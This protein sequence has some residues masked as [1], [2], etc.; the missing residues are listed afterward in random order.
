MTD[1]SETLHPLWEEAFARIREF[2][3]GETA[4]DAP[5]PGHQDDLPPALKHLVKVFGLSPFE[6]DIVTLCL[7]M[8]LDVGMTRACAKGHGGQPTGPTAGLVLSRIPGA[9]WSAFSPDGSLRQWRLV[10]L[11]DNLSLTSA[12]LRLDERIVHH[13]L[14]L[15][16]MDARLTTYLGR[17]AGPAWLPG[18]LRRRAHQLAEHLREPLPPVIQLVAAD[19]RDAMLLAAAACGSL[20]LP[21]WRLAADNLPATPAERDTFRLLWQRE[22]RLSPKGLL[23]R[24]GRRPAS[25]AAAAELA[26]ASPWVFVVGGGRLPTLQRPLLR[27]PVAKPPAMEQTEAWK[28]LLGVEVHRVN[29][30][31]T[32]VTSQFSLGLASLIHAAGRA[33]RRLRNGR[34]PGRVLWEVCREAARPR[35]SALAQEIRPMAC[36]DDLVLPDREQLVLRTI[37]A[38]VRHQHRVYEDGGFAEKSRR[39]LG[40]SALF[41]GDSGTGKTMAAEVL[42]GE[43]DLGLFRIDL[44]AVVDKYIGET[45]KNLRAVFNAAE[46]G[47]AILLFDEADALFGKRSDVRDSHDRYANIEVSYLLQRMEN[48]RGLAILTTNMKS[49]LDRAFIRRIRFMVEFPFPNQQL[50]TRIWRKVFPPNTGTGTLDFTRLAQLNVTGGTIRNIALNAAFLAADDARPVDMHHVYRAAQVEYAKQEKQLTETE[51]GGWL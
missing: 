16:P 21:L 49:A 25:R 50:R 23:I 35:L 6:R 37:T 42:A 11:H 48:Y 7:G 33:R 34:V 2:L 1:R 38:Q 15:D 30:D 47:G 3:I 20:H 51:T 28:Q 10:E 36:W 14:G 13:L 39:G 29:G 26:D 31:L 19:E 46:D 43:L 12:R 41:F 44:S 4:S 5:T 8:E 32:Q 9:H 17:T 18:S 45:E 27:S 24:C 40:I 22:T